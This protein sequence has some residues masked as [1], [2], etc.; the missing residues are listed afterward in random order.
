MLH[1]TV[2]EIPSQ[3]VADTQAHVSV[4]RDFYESCDPNDPFRSVS[5]AADRA[6]REYGVDYDDLG[7]YDD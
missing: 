2:H 5:D 4:V 7:G 3:R 6:C 1:P